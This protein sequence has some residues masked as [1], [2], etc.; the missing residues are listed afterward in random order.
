MTVI[1]H[2]SPLHRVG[3]GGW[4]CTLKQGGLLQKILAGWLFWV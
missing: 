1:N 4:L 3:G 2:T